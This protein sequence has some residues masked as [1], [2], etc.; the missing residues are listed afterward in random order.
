VRELGDWTARV[1]AFFRSQSVPL[2]ELTMEP[3]AALSPGDVSDERIRI[4]GYAD[5]QLRDPLGAR[6]ADDDDGREDVDAA[7]PGHPA[8]R[9]RAEYSPR[10]CPRFGNSC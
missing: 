7:C 9:R 6:R 2:S 3:L 8:R 5:A 4:K 10:A 1:R